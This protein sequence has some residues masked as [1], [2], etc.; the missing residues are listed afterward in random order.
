MRA[1]VKLNWKT[2]VRKEAL[3]VT[4]WGIG[5]VTLLTID[6]TLEKLFEDFNHVL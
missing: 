5:P 6:V 2:G 4:A 1:K 3:N